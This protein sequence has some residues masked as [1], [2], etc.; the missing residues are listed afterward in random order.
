MNKAKKNKVINALYNA[1]CHKTYAIRDIHRNIEHI[2]AIL[3]ENGINPDKVSITDMLDVSYDVFDDVRNNGKISQEYI[4]E[5]WF[6]VSY[7]LKKYKK[8]AIHF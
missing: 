4:K 7:F 8:Y 5:K 1:E 6:D 3:A 2:H